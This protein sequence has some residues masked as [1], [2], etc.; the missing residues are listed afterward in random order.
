MRTLTG[1]FE[2]IDLNTFIQR[3][4]STKFSRPWH[5]R[6]DRFPLGLVKKVRI[7]F[8][9]QNR[10]DRLLMY[11]LPAKTIDHT[12]STGAIR[13]KQRRKLL[14]DRQVFV[15]KE[16]FVDNVD[17]NTAQIQFAV[18]EFQIVRPADERIVTG[19]FEIIAKKLKFLDRWQAFQIDNRDHGLAIGFAAAEFVPTA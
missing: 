6:T 15:Y 19:R 16:S 13:V 5:V 10:K 9:S 12:D 8:V 7:F 1:P 14:H 18:I 3:L 2:Q 17:G 4:L 11:E